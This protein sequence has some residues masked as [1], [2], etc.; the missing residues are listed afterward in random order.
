MTAAAAVFVAR[1]D[2]LDDNRS[3]RPRKWFKSTENWIILA[4]METI[5]KTE[6][7]FH[8][9]DPLGSTW[10]Y[11]VT[12]GGRTLVSSEAGSV[13]RSYHDHTLILT[14]SGKGSIRVAGG[15]FSAHP[16]SLAWLDTSR[17]YAH[18]AEA[19]HEW[20]YLW[21]AVKGYGLDKLHGRIGLSEEPV[22]EQ[23]AHLGACFDA[24]LQALSGH[25]PAADAA[26][27]AQIGLIMRDLFA[28]RQ[29]EYE[30]S[31]SDP[32]SRLMQHLRK[33]LSRRW[34]IS[35]M[36]TSAGLSPSQLHRRFNAAAGTSPISWLRQERMLLASH[37]LTA[38][39]D[40]IT[41][42]AQRCG[43]ADPFHF[44]RDFKRHHACAPR[45]FRTKARG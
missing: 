39:S 4:F 19:G 42:I 1:M 13:S 45:A 30:A 12:A 6:V 36:A 41:L 44:S 20:A 23:M 10:P 7:Y 11:A 15:T 25:L 32:I 2:I 34:D 17:N 3:T 31:R 21:V 40:S 16:G 28:A 22:I 43:Y 24:I 14:L 5:S 9:I 35:A 26:M 38:T 8:S 37:L 33:D 18:E 29:D 27:N